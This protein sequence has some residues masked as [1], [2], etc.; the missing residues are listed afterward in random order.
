VQTSTRGALL[1]AHL[2]IEQRTLARRLRAQ[3]MSLRD[4]AKQIGCGHAGVDVMLRGQ[5]REARPVESAL[6][7]SSCGTKPAPT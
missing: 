2:N 5:S 4:I 6:A 7:L 3:K 1:T